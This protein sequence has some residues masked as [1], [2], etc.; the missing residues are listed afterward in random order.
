MTD[1]LT[2]VEWVRLHYGPTNELNGEQ[3]RWLL[4]SLIRYYGSQKSCAETLGVGERYLSAIINLEC[5]LD[6]IILGVLGFE[7]E[8]MYHL[9]GTS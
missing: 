5:N 9:R 2:P 4:E 8:P 1:K 6:S 3:M 7:K